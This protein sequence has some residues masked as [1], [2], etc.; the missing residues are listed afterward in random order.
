MV[1]GEW[2]TELSYSSRLPEAASGLFSG[3]M[4]RIII[5]IGGQVSPGILYPCRVLNINEIGSSFACRECNT[6]THEIEP[7]FIQLEGHCIGN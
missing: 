1:V 2:K 3:E 4:Y 7:W 6:R 5:S